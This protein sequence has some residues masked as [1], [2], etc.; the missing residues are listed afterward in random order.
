[1]LSASPQCKCKAGGGFCIQALAPQPAA[2]A[3]SQPAHPPTHTH[4]APVGVLQAVVH[5]GLRLPVHGAAHAGG[6]DAEHREVMHLVLQG[7]QVGSWG[8]AVRGSMQDGGVGWG[9][10]HTAGGAL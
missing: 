9:R 8:G 10:V 5:A 1:M 6:G 7:G 4:L 3:T 2:P